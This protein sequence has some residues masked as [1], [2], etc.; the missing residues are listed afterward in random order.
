MNR[1]DRQPPRSKQVDRRDN[2][3]YALLQDNYDSVDRN[4]NATYISR[5]ELYD[6]IRQQIEH[7]DGL[8]NQRLNWLL[9]SHAFLFA[10]FTTVI[11]NDKSSTKFQSF[12][13]M[14]PLIITIAGWSLNLFSFFGIRSAHKSLKH[15]RLTWYETLPYKREIGMLNHGFP[16]ITWVGNKLDK[17]INAAI[18]TPVLIMIIWSIFAFAVVPD[19]T[20]QI[21]MLSI[22][23]T[24]KIL[25]RIIIVVMSV[26][27][28]TKMLWTIFID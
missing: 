2:L 5:K 23:I 11:T 10:A 28:V 15:L 21:N 27:L 22:I 26:L 9:L 18:G 1:H 7:E 6:M 12:Y 16:Q 14:I 8:V 20:A 13:D 17:A 4:K 24:L 19:W 3:L 25:A